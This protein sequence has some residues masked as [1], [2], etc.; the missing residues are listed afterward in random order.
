MVGNYLTT[1]GQDYKE[2]WKLALSLGL[3]LPD[4]IKEKANVV[5]SNTKLEAKA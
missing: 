4:H 2:D 3:E 1:P 5:L